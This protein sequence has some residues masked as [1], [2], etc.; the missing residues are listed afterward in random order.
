LWIAD[1]GSQSPHPLSAF[2]ILVIPQPKV[3]TVLSGPLTL[4]LSVKSKEKVPFY[5]LDKGKALIYS[6]PII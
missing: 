1:G 4:D 6:G 3:N 5:E 2:P